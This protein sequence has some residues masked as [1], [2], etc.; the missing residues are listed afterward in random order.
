M[1]LEKVRMAGVILRKA[2]EEAR[3]RLTRDARLADI[4]E[5]V[6]SRIREL[7]GEPAFP[8]NISLDADA[9]HDTPSPS[10][11][12]IIGDSL[13]KID[14][15]VHVD[16][17]IAD[18]AFSMSFSDESLHK[19]LI[20]ASETAL[21]EAVKEARPGTTVGF[22]GEVIEETIRGFGFLPV[23]NL[24][25]HGLKRYEFHAEPQ[26]F[27]I[28]NN[29]DR[30]LE[31]GEVIAIEPFATNGS[32]FVR[33]TGRAEIYSL[34]S[35][36]PVRDREER[37]IVE[38]A[39]SRKGLPFSRREVWKSALTGLAI[40]RLA[41]KGILYSYPVLRDSANGLVSQAEHTV[42]VLDRP[43]TVT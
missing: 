34:A 33:E 5:F 13:V 40:S 4:A 35:P 11:S 7:G 39:I 32:G 15:G 25:G 31:Y 14:I 23:A 20:R 36:R 8:V 2:R 16:G 22:I 42:I 17:Y 37:R 6:E 18:S 43:E 41:S 29:S 12:R 3:R 9:A 19:D 38:Y 30:E 1:D 26:I 27:N 28:R 10:D 24:T 21:K